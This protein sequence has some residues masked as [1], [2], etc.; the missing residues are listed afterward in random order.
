LDK[1]FPFSEPG[2]GCSPFNSSTWEAEV[3]RFLLYRVSFR[4]ASD[5][6]ENLVWKKRKK[7]GRKEKKFSGHWRDGLAVKSNCYSC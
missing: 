5:T 3:G 6:Q 1:G 2:C 4:I 7:E